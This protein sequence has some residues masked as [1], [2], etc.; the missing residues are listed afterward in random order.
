MLH[1][2]HPLKKIIAKG[3]SSTLDFKNTISSAKKIA[4]T[5]VA[6]SNSVGG[7]ILIGVKDNGYIVGVQQ[8]EEIFMINSAATIYSKPN[9]N[10]EVILHEFN[11]LTVVEIVMR[12][13][14]QKPYYAQDEDNKWWVYVRINDKN[15]LT[16]KIRLEIMKAKT[17]QQNIVFQYTNDDKTLLSYLEKNNSITFSTYC[18]LLFLSQNEAI[19]KLVILVNTGILAIHTT[20]ESEYFT[21]QTIH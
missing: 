6:F 19:K 13:G 16:S 1:P 21:R 3:E 5:L 11:D 14:T 12:E 18:N 7:S 15:L 20:E 9:I 17:K 8:E 10:Y 4:K 2:I